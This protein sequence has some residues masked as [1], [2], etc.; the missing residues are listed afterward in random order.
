MSETGSNGSQ[1]AMQSTRVLVIGLVAV[2]LVLGLGLVA[3]IIGQNAAAPAITAQQAGEKV[4]A[5]ANSQDECVVCH[6]RTTPGIV[7]QYGHS[8]MAAAEVSCQD[9]HEVKADYPGSVEHEGVYV[10]QSPTMLY[11]LMSPWSV[12]NRSTLNIRPCLRL[13]PKVGLL[14]IRPA[15]LYTTWKGPR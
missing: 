14:L 9:C 3:M 12:P 15:I 4:D 10:L 11:R 13:S 6:K 7:Q 2:V 8:T 5:L 1:K